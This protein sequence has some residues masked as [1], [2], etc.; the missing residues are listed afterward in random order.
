[1]GF[2]AYHTG[3]WQWIYWVLA[4]TNGVQCVLYFFFSPETR[5]MRDSQLAAVPQGSQFKRKYLHFTRIDKTPLTL[6]E[7]LFPFHFFAYPNIVIPSV[8]YSI[9]FGFTS[10]LLTVE[11]PQIFT[12]KFGFN[13]QQIGLQFIGMIVGSVLGEQIGGR[14][15]DFFMRRFGT[16][17]K[18]AHESR[19][20]IAY[21]GFITAIVGLIV[22]CVQV[23]RLKSYN[24]TPIVGIA[25]AAFGNQIITTVLITYAV[26]CYIEHAG[27]IGIFVSLVRNTWG[28]IGMYSFSFSVCLRDLIESTE[29]ML[30]LSR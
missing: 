24:V 4:I 5:F 17:S 30:M 10:V 28:F 15:S 8:A 12:P 2:V 11:I 27:S 13:A 19:L 21:P 7:F 25:I 3:G 14:G 26:D 1:M 22:F 16:K 20:W 9:V 6:R 18:S 29:Q 23:D